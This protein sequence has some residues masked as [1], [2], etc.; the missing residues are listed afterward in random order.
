MTGRAE[1]ARLRSGNGEASIYSYPPGRDF[2]DPELPANFWDPAPGPASHGEA[3]VVGNAG[4]SR[5]RATARASRR[6]STS[7]DGDRLT[8]AVGGDNVEIVPSFDRIES[9]GR[10][11][12]CVAF[13]DQEPKLKHQP[14]NRDATILWDAALVRSGYAGS[15]KPDRQIADFLVGKSPWCWGTPNSWRRQHEPRLGCISH[16]VQPQRHLSRYRDRHSILTPRQHF[17]SASLRR[18]VGRRAG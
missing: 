17:V 3:G 11:V 7:T 6:R 18:A 13:H 5:F 16:R 1:L 4:S 14:I 12:P 9:A 15:L 2:D 10:V 8:A